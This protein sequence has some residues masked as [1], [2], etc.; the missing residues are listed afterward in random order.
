MY[1]NIKKLLVYYYL[2]CYCWH[3]CLYTTWLDGESFR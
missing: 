2:Y 3:Y 1:D